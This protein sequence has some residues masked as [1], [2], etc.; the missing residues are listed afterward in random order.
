MMIMITMTMM[1]ANI[2]KNI[3]IYRDDTRELNTNLYENYLQ[4]KWI[5]KTFGQIFEV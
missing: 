2:I 4:L 1:T 3:V 5:F